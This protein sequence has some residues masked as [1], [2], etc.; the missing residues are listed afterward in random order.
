MR[1]CERLL[2]NMNRN[3]AKGSSGTLPVTVQ[4]ITQQASG[5]GRGMI[6]A[7]G[8]GAPIK[9]GQEQAFRWKLMGR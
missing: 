8:N 9:T 4:I 3:T 1:G 5:P 7:P 2:I 6:C